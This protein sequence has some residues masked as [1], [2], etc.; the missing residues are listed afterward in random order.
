MQLP[1]SDLILSCTYSA[2]DSP[3][4]HSMQKFGDAQLD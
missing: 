4:S 3:H 1:I 2:E